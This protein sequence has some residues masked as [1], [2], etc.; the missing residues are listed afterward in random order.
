MAR[1]LVVDDDHGIRE[2]IQMA[3]QEQGYD[4]VTDDGTTALHAVQTARPDLILLD[5]ILRAP[6]TEAICHTLL[7]DEATAGV[8]IV[9]ISAVS[10]L[11]VLAQQLAASDYLCKPF[12]LNDLY[13]VVARWVAKSGP[14]LPTLT[15]AGTP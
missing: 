8:P 15:P 5:L 9:L 1:I 10:E 4:V 12:D 14:I 11:D 6:G 2:L 7:S 13:T 3:L